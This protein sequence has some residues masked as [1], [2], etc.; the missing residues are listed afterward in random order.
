MQ[1]QDFTKCE[2]LKYH[3]FSI[4][5]CRNKL[6]Q[7]SATFFCNIGV[8][9]LLYS[10]HVDSLLRSYISGIPEKIPATDQHYQPS[11][12]VSGVGQEFP[13][14]YYSLGEG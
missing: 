8:N 1:A 4:S 14:N 2:F 7:Q 13:F 10:I 11:G 9:F 12:L 5:C 3:Q 6:F